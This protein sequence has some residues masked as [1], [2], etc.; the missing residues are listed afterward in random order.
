MN[1]VLLNQNQVLGILKINQLGRD[2]IVKHLC[3]VI[4]ADEHCFGDLLADF[5]DGVK[6]RKRILEDH[7]DLMAANPMEFLLGNLGQIFAFVHDRTRIDMGVTCQNAH[8]GFGG[9]RLTRTRFT[10]DAKRLTFIQI[11]GNATNGA[12]HTV[13]GEK[14][15]SKIAN[16]KNG[17]FPCG[18]RSDIL[19]E[20]NRLVDFLFCAHS[21]TPFNEGLKA[22]R[23][24]LP[25]RLNEIIIMHMMSEPQIMR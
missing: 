5:H 22:S 2:L 7:A 11:E 12:N 9:Y 24:P 6:R 16:R 25:K 23:K 21:E 17:L 10:D 8:D 1:F 3:Q 4:A 13:I 18:N 14:G 15:N 19:G 20:I